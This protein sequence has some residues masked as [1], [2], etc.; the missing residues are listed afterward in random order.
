MDLANSATANH[1]IQCEDCCRRSTSN[2]Y[3]KIYIHSTSAHHAFHTCQA[4][5]QT[6]PER[7]AVSAHLDTGYA[8]FSHQQA[9][10]KAVKI[11]VRGTGEASLQG[12][13]RLPRWQ[14]CQLLSQ[15]LSSDTHPNAA[16]PAASVW[17]WVERKLQ[18]T[19]FRPK[20]PQDEIMTLTKWGK[21]YSGQSLASIFALSSEVVAWSPAFC[22]C[23]CV[24]LQECKVKLVILDSLMG[25]TYT[26]TF[27]FE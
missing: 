5:W 25:S 1:F 4:D 24:C 17:P 13:G 22:V 26:N 6:D 11:P 15:D 3:I 21:T 18:R 2:L 8:V 9:N 23:V 10:G 14:C 27:M 12:P 7:R 19:F 16:S 20:P